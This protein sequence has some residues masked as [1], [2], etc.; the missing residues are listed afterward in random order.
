[1]LPMLGWKSRPIEASTE[2]RRL[3]AEARCGSNVICLAPLFKSGFLIQGRDDVADPQAGH[4]KKDRTG[5]LLPGRY[6][7]AGGESSPKYN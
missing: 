4:L 6:P 3:A 7:T 1:M 2:L 5:R